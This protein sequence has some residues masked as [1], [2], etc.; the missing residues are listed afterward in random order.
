MEFCLVPCLY[1][2]PLRSLRVFCSLSKG[3]SKGFAGDLSNGLVR[4]LPRGFVRDLFRDI[5]NNPK[6]FLNVLIRDY[7]LIF[8]RVLLEVFFIVF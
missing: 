4:G 1:I 5:S 3:L 6:R 2:I 8:I 7:I